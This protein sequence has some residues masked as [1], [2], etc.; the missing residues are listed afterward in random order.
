[1]KTYSIYELATGLLRPDKVSFNEKTFE[2]QSLAYAR[3]GFGLIEGRFNDWEHRIDLA[4]LQPIAYTPP[5]TNENDI[6]DDKTKQWY[7]VEHVGYMLRGKR[8][9][10]LRETDWVSIRAAD[11]GKPVAKEWKDYRQA[12]RD[13]TTQPGF[14]ANVVWPSK[15]QG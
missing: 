7:S 13:L 9:K 1:M 6:W 15:P 8:D 4:T 3:K 5:K 12:L 2:L 10:L 11:E 14:P